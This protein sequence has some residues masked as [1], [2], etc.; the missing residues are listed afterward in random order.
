MV[1]RRSLPL[2]KKD[3]RVDAYIAKSQEFAK[4][5]LKL[6]R[7]TVHKACP[8]VEEKIKWGF[9]HFDYKGMLCSMAAFKQ[10]C[11]FTFWKASL[12]RDP[13]KILDVNRENAMGHF[14][15]IVSIKNLPAEKIFIRYIK[16]AVKLNDGDIKLPGKS[17]S[18]E[19]KELAVP[20]YFI[21]SLKKNKKAFEAFNN[22]SYSNKKEYVNWIIEAKTDETRN[23]RIA[24]TLEWLA[25]GKSRNWKYAKC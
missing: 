16:E 1:E 23:K 14:G 18:K 2:A 17:K 10:H 13:G 19:K 7:E 22:F 5:I 6:I 20:D 8:A 11:A 25:E 9:P 15:K 24:T 21:K 4:P 3:P 12:M